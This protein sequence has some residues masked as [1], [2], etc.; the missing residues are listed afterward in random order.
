[1]SAPA[2]V[3]SFVQPHAQRMPCRT[4]SLLRWPLIAALIVLM[5][6]PQLSRAQSS[7]ALSSTSSSTP[8][9]Q[10]YT[11]SGEPA[12][13]GDVVAAS[14][15]V[16][17]VFVGEVHNDPGAHALQDTLFAALAAR[18]AAADSA[19]PSRPLALSLEMLERDVQP[20]VDEYLSGRISERH[21]VTASRMWDRYRSA[22][23]PLVQRAK[24]QGF[25]ILAANAPRRYVS[26]VASAGRG[27][28]DSLSSWAKQWI[29]P[30]PYPGPSEAYRAKWSERM[31]EAMPP[32]HG[33]SPHG[34]SSTGSSADTTASTPDDTTQAQTHASPNASPHGSPHGAAMQARM[35]SMLQ[36]QALWDA[37]MAYTIAEHLLRRPDALVLHVT[38]SFHVSEGTGTPE[39]LRHYRPDA[40]MLTVVVEP[41]ADPTQFDE[42]EH[43]GLGDFVVLTP[44]GSGSESGSEA[45]GE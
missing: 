36:A 38:G 2:A 24:E 19:A 34:A 43:R 27:S 18:H 41:T 6:T 1:M 35:Q 30:L 42:S 16:S 12:S 29:A 37:T 22:Y 20:V 39:A 7:S 26:R 15:T 32:G 21:F 4:A 28:L 25:P 40:R 23:R 14:D 10:V 31:R 8:A 44:D 45:S 5:G 13:V 17:V 9:V 33:G 11:G 3:P